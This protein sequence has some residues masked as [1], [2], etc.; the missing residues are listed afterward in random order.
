M[1]LGACRTVLVVNGTQPGA[2][3]AELLAAV[4]AA[5]A[6]TSAALLADKGLYES[7]QKVRTLQAKGRG[8][9]SSLQPAMYIQQAA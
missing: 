8:L 9:S 1:Q 2:R 4:S 7:S 6:A 5:L 3:G